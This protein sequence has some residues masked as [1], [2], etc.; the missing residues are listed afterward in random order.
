MIAPSSMTPSTPRLVTPDFSVTIAPNVA[1]N[2]PAPD[3]TKTARNAIRLPGPLHRPAYRKPGLSRSA[4]KFFWES[5][6]CG[7]APQG[8]APWTPL[9]DG[10]AGSAHNLKGGTRVEGGKHG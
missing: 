4:H 10:A 2:S 9:S 7:L 8:S 5:Q 6:G 3:R 1:G